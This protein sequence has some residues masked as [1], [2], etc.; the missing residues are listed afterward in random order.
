MRCK[1]CG[2]EIPKIQLKVN[3]L[4]YT[5]YPACPCE[6][7][8]YEKTLKRLREEEKRGEILRYHELSFLPRGKEEKTFATFL[9]REGTERALEKAK[10][11]ISAFREGNPFSLILVGPSGSGKT[12]LALAI[13]HALEEEYTTLFYPVPLL[14][15]RLNES[16]DR[17]GE[18]ELALF[19]TLGEADLLI[20]DDLGVERKSEKNLERIH[21]IVDTRYLLRKPLVITTN[22][23]PEGLEK[24]YGERVLDRLF[25][26]GEFVLCKPS[27]SFRREKKQ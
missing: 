15:A 24:I 7:R 10:S 16:Y 18:S 9:P 25:E 22:L 20:L 2:R 12:H 26:V 23:S 3:G 13:Y 19:E 14:L 17:E 27:G 1:F 8:E 6:V 5:L 4:E 21:T 11:F